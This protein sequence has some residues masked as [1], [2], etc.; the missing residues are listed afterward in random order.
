M[1]PAPTTAGALPDKIL[2][3][4]TTI[5]SS[6]DGEIVFVTCIDEHGYVGDSEAYASEDQPKSALPLELL[7]SFP[8]ELGVDTVLV[9][10]RGIDSLDFIAE[11]D[12]EF[13]RN[14]IATAD[15]E[16]IEVLDH[17]IVRDGRPIKLR[18]ET[19]L[20]D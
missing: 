2:E 1:T 10:S 6:A 8:K 12:L 13:T 16:G 7:F 11:G 4:L 9:T 17:V 15:E 19:D 3:S 20:W 5:V 18:E 14:L